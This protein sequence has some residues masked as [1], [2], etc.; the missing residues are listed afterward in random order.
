VR[1]ALLARCGA[2]LA[3][4]RCVPLPR[5]ECTLHGA[6]G[7]ATRSSDCQRCGMTT[8]PT[9][10]AKVCASIAYAASS[11]RTGLVRDFS[12]VIVTLTAAV[13][14]TRRA[15]LTVRLAGDVLIAPHTCPAHVTFAHRL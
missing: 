10:R 7:A 1:A 15:S 6:A 4:Y 12:F 11:W 8:A 9:T 14:D 13:V 2:G 5:C 3:K